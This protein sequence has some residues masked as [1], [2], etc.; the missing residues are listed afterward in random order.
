MSRLLLPA[1]RGQKNVVVDPR[2]SKLNFHVDRTVHFA[3][4]Y[5]DVG[6]REVGGKRVLVFMFHQFS[7]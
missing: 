2:L 4:G 7:K 1:Y 3:H 5:R 6:G